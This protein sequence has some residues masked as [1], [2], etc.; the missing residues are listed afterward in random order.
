MPIAAVLALLETYGPTVWSL[1]TTY[2][3]TLIGLIK[4]YGPALKAQVGPLIAASV[5]AG[6]LEQDVGAVVAKLQALA[7]LLGG[8]SSLGDLAD[9]FGA[10]G[11]APVE[12]PAMQHA[13]GSRAR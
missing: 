12:S 5:E 10:A 4:Q 13:V 7:P 2:G 6:T 11:G 1:A 8:L 9:A 3:P